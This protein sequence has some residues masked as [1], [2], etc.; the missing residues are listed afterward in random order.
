MFKGFT[1][2]LEKILEEF[3]QKS[4]YFIF[5]VSDLEKQEGEEYKFDILSPE[6]G[7]KL[8]DI[9]TSNGGTMSTSK[10]V[11]FSE[12]HPRL[13]RYGAG[14]FESWIKINKKFLTELNQSNSS[15]IIIIP[16][17]HACKMV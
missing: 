6:L 9:I 1:E 7:Q 14:I 3:N 16:D 5:C 13:K 11:K 17:N 8:R 15:G 12:L 4:E 10:A 2:N